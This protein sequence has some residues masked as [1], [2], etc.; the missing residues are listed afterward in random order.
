MS[1]IILLG[2]FRMIK[3]LFSVVRTPQVRITILKQQ[4]TTEL[5]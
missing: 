5:V 4:M 3:T 1:K 2:R